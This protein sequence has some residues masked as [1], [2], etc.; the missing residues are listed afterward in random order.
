MERHLLLTVSADREA[1]SNVRFIRHFFEDLCRLRITLF[2]VAAR[3]MDSDY[4]FV[5]SILET[6]KPLETPVE[7]LRSP[8]ARAALQHTQEW[9][10]RQG[11]PPEH[12]ATKAVFSRFGIVHDIIQE[13]HAGK[14]D[15]V[16]LG[17]RCVSWFDTL[18]DDSVTSRILWERIDFPVW[19]CRRPETGFTRHVLLCLDGSDASLRM[20]DHVGFMCAE[21]PGQEIH[22]FHVANAAG[23]REGLFREARQALSENGVHESRIQELAPQGDS[24]AQA[25]LQQ[26][27]A[28]KYAVVALGRRAVSKSDSLPA[29]SGPSVSEN[30]LKSFEDFSLWI[31]K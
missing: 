7:E 24:P 30:I 29:Q 1:A 16:V 17:K 8:E 12:I 13:G 4:R 6:G 19:I 23:P 2:Y 21:V 14:Y 20:A 26:A 9:L 10:M 3:P 18:F 22:L 11:C 15:A 25:I 31:S 28:G 5:P 27:R